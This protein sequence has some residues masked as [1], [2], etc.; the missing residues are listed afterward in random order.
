MDLSAMLALLVFGV[1]GVIIALL[2]VI[3]FFFPEEPP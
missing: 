3:S 1:A 2:W